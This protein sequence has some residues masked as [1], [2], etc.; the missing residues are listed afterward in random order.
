MSKPVPFRDRSPE[1]QAKMRDALDLIE[2]L[3]HKMWEIDREIRRLTE[4]RNNIKTRWHAARD[5][6]YTSIGKENPEPHA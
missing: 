3:G 5:E 6:F 2:T 4:T 1:D